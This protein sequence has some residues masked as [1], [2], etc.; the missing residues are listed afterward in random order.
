MKP[1]EYNYLT[2]DD[3][4]TIYY[5]FLKWSPEELLVLAGMKEGYLVVDLCCGA[6]AR[7]TL[8]ALE[9]GAQ[10]VASVD[11]TQHVMDIKTK[12]IPEQHR[13]KVCAFCEPVTSFLESC[14]KN[15]DIDIVACRQGINY[16]FNDMKHTHWQS[17]VKILKDDGAFVFN[18]FRILPPTRPVVKEYFNKGKNFN[19]IYWSVGSTVHH[20]QIMEGYPPHVTT[21]DHITNEEY[22]NTLRKYF[23][24]VDIVSREHTDIYTCREPIR[25]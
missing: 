15:K 21:F 9:M 8:S 7:L 11:R 19:E 3:Y 17:L 16:F 6:N 18:T 20:V 22:E 2:A 25:K 10:M 1:N 4:N 14:P 24:R 12:V 5:R 13:H 23:N